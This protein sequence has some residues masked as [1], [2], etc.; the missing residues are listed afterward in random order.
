MR[1]KKG[2][3]PINYPR[4]TPDPVAKD[5]GDRENKNQVGQIRGPTKTQCSGKRKGLQPETRRIPT[6]A[7]KDQKSRK[8]TEEIGER[9]PKLIN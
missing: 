2:L 1:A 5:Q 8:K 4:K 9:P 6:G 3:G 7:R